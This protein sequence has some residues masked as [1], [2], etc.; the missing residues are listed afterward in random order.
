MTIIVMSVID[1]HK[2]HLHSNSVL[3]SYHA[4][5]ALMDSCSAKTQCNASK[6]AQLAQVKIIKRTNVR[7]ARIFI[8]HAMGVGERTSSF[9]LRLSLLISCFKI[10]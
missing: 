8:Q 4:R 1:S 6:N 10:R 9:A 7:L 2:T 5:N 3:G